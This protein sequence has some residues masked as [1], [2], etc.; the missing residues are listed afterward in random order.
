MSEN[1]CPH[2]G[3]PFS[4]KIPRIILLIALALALGLLVWRR[5]ELGW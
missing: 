5:W 2:S 3:C 1:E 4:K